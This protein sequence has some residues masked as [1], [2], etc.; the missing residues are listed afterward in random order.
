MIA[1]VLAGLARGLVAALATSALLAHAALAAPTHDPAARA[2][3]ESYK[4]ITANLDPGTAALGEKV[5]NTV[6]VSCHEHGLN[7]APQRFILAFMTPE[8]ILKALTEG[9]MRTQAEALSLEEKQAV[10]QYLTSRGLGSGDN[11]DT[12]VMCA[13]ATPELDALPVLRGWGF[14]AGHS[15]FIPDD[16]AG[17]TRDNVGRLQLKYALAFPG[18]VRAR[19]QPLVAGDTLF[20]GSQSGTLYALDLDSGCAHWTFQASAEIKTGVLIEHWNPG[21]AAADPLLFFGDIIGFQYAIRARSGELVWRKRMDEHPALTLSGTAALTA[22]T[23]F[24]PTS[25]LEEGTA[26]DPTYPCCTFRGALVALDPASGE[27]KF[28]TW[29]VPSPQPRGRNASGAQQFGPSGVP[30]WTVPLVDEQRGLVYVSTGDNYSS[31]ATGL[32][33]SIVAIDMKTGATRWHYQATADD[34]WNGSCAELVQHNCPEEDGPDVDFGSSPVLATGSDGKA[35]VVAAD[36]AGQ[37]VA[38]D[39]DT[40]KLVWKKRV[41]RGGVVGG[42]LFGLAAHDG[43]LYVPV[44]DVPDGRSY[45]IP[46]R[47][48]LYALDVASGDYRWQSPAPDDVCRGRPACYPGNQT[49]PGITSQLLFAGAND[50]Y[51]RVYDIR[52]GS[53]LWEADTAREFQTVSGASAS[54]GSIGGSASVIAVGGRLVTN[55]GYGFAGKMPGGVLLVYE[56]AAPE[57]GE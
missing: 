35:L 50:G 25:S 43:V 11:A 8:S 20:V 10:A 1:P 31:P 47:P 12:T 39:P 15:H 4:D 5:Y 2:Q 23:L 21:D 40:G 34:A 38:V 27:E 9:V 33:D 42:I 29:L 52:D 41:G 57:A 53:V 19:S 6:C 36:K 32:S 54:G 55:S 56:V 16:Y 48:G 37:V 45:A 46:A 14:D 49:V 17:I 28:R 18:A 30:I 13:S 24:V 3:S 51:L 44:S 26:S 7:R 22:D